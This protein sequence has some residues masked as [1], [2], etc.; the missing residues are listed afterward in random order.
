[1]AEENGG[2][3][4]TT[5]STTDTPDWAEKFEAQRKVNRDLESKGRKDLK[6]IEALELEIANLREGSEPKDRVAAEIEKAKK[7]ATS[8]ALQAANARIVRSEIRALAAG[9]FADPADAVAF[10]NPDDFGVN[11][12]LEPD[13]EAIKAALAELLKSKPHLAAQG[14]RWGGGG[15][16]GPRETDVRP[17]DVRGLIAAGMRQSP[18][19]PRS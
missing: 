18:K 3:P 2:T 10:L 17:T 9:T 14:K 12:D 6:R 1:M 4:E 8:A 15:D 13:S 5:E 19:N 11:D 16:N 7:E